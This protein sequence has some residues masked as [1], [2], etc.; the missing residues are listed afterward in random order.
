MK[1]NDDIKALLDDFQNTA[2]EPVEFDEAAILAAY[3]KHNDN[4]SLPIKILSVFGGILASLAFLG[5]LFIA[6]LYD[7]EVGLLM[8]GAIFVAGSILINKNY[9]R[10]IIDTI[11][12][13]LYIIGFILIGLALNLLEVDED[14]IMFIYILLA[15][16]SMSIVQ[17]YIISF[18]AVLIINASLLGLLIENDAYDLVHG[19][20]TA[21]A[22]GTTYLFL[23]EAKIITT[24]VALSKLYNPVRI[25]LVFS[26][27]L[28]LACLGKKGMLPLSPNYIWLSAVPIIAVIVY[29]VSN[30]FE[31]LDI[32][33]KRHKIGI[34]VFTLLALVP[35]AL[36]PAISGALLLILLSFLVNY[37]TGLFLGIISFIYFISQY[38][39][40][41]K[42]TLLTKSILLFSTGV[43][44]LAIY[45]FTHKK[46]ASH[47]KV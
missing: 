21:L 23:N 19:Y 37:R 25:G 7:S 46:L 34:Y 47:E 40:D 1:T 5:F 39:Y 10:I 9:D 6:G 29:L 22:L 30:L 2:E 36:S 45:L 18:V 38:Y 33:E 3:E 28:G 41:L 16:G 43:V 15:L 20:V 31:L 14:P 42:F 27:L 35:T 4:Q 26:F 44:F 32:T 8:F 11:S 24:S 13:S 12:V 17:S